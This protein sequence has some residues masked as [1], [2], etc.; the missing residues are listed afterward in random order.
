VKNGENYTVSDEDILLMKKMLGKS[1]ETLPPLSE[2]Y[3]ILNEEEI[4]N[5]LELMNTNERMSTEVTF[6]D[7]GNDK[8]A[9]VAAANMSFDDDDIPF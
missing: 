9:A 2:V 7:K 1:F 4:L 8:L 5:I 6:S 3:S